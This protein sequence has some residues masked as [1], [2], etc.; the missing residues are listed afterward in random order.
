MKTNLK[1]IN[2][3][4]TLISNLKKAHK[5][6]WADFDNDYTYTIGRKFIKIIK[7]AG[8]PSRNKSVWGFI[9]EDGSILKAASWNAPAKH[10]RGNVHD[11]YPITGMRIYSPD[12]LK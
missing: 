9:Q 2:N 7:N 8:T 6:Q 5:E 12:Y 3:V 1:L 4:E 10:S 11:G